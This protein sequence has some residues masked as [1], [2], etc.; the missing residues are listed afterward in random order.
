MADDIDTALRRLAHE[1]LP[2]GL[3]RLE[4][5][6]MDRIEAEAEVR[7]AQP[8]F[9]VGMGIAAVA[10]VIGMTT[11]TTPTH[12]DAAPLKLSV[13]SVNAALSPAT[14]LATTR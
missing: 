1:P 9:G 3:T 6:V 8:S 13:F 2:A 11:A 7:L 10:L 5:G 14:L 12:A 4:R